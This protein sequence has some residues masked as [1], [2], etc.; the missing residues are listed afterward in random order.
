MQ[1]QLHPRIHQENTNLLTGDSIIKTSSCYFNRMWKEGFYIGT[2]KSRRR[3]SV[4]LLS[5]PGNISIVT[6]LARR[7]QGQPSVFRLH[8]NRHVGGETCEARGSSCWFWIYQRF[9]WSNSTN[10]SCSFNT[11]FPKTN[12]VIS[13]A[14]NALRTFI[15]S[16]KV[17]RHDVHPLL[18]ISATNNGTA[19]E[20]III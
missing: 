12:K 3:I 8:A 18:I 4:L 6:L 2:D 1:Y 17:L 5:C 16:F 11:A 7:G 15:G 14:F 9:H 19:T 10:N 20:M 13:T